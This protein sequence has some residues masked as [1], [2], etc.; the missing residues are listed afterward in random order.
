VSAA[1]RRLDPLLRTALVLLIA[2]VA[3]AGFASWSWASAPRTPSAAQARDQALRAGEQ[4][5]LNF[6]TLDY[7]HV[8]A[9]LRLW[10]RSSTGAL[11]HQVVVGQSLFA[12]Q[13]REARTITTAHI[14]DA[15][16]TSLNERAGTASLI[17]AIQVTVTPDH[18]A[19]DSKL[20]R[21]AG[22]LTRTASGW[23]LSTL[24]QAPV[25]KVTS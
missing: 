18:A 2:A 6:N 17:V 13:I 7:R 16:L 14:L 11:R 25:Q 12:Q 9:G 5:V 8:G 3:F 21:L 24:S 23:K 1:I 4:A 20:T 10:E 15:A 22:Q 19:P